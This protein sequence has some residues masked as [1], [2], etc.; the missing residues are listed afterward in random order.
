MSTLTH[1]A[2]AYDLARTY[3]LLP[4]DG[5]KY[6]AR[7]YNDKQHTFVLAHWNGRSNVLVQF[8]GAQLPNDP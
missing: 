1:D 5:S 4:V 6:E 2:Y 8:D 7:S 3:G